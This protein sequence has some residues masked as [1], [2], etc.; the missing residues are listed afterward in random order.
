MTGRRGGP[1]TVAGVPVPRLR[2]PIAGRPEQAGAVG[3]GA[4]WRGRNKG[5]GQPAVRCEKVGREGE[6]QAWGGVARGRLRTLAAE[7]LAK[8]CPIFVGEA[9]APVVDPASGV[10]TGLRQRMTGVSSTGF[11]I[12]R[13]GRRVALPASSGLRDK[14]AGAGLG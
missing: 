13:S 8:R 11:G 2:G 9:R 14:R 5:E 7:A 10:G 1:E 4:G 3:S 6:A 12:E